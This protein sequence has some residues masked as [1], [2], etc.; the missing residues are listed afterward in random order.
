[1]LSQVQMEEIRAVQTVQR[2]RSRRLGSRELA[3]R[4]NVLSQL[5][6]LILENEKEWLGALYQDLKK[7]IVE[8]YSSELAVLLNEIEY[9]EKH[10]SRWMDPIKK[11]RWVFNGREKTET[12]QHPFGSILVIAPWNYPLQLALMPVIG[13][14]AAGNGIVLKPSEYAPSISQMLV[15]LVPQY[16][17]EEVFYV[18]EGGVETSKQ[19]TSLKWDFIF[20]T[21]SPTTGRKVYEAAAKNLT[22]VVLELGGKNPYIVDSSAMNKE[23]VQQIAWG[24]FLNA[25]QSC[26]APD[27]VYVQRESYDE[28]LTQMKATLIEFY[29]EKPEKAKDFGRIIHEKQFEKIQSYLADG[30]VF[31]GGVSSRDDLYISPTLLANPE[32][33]S[34][35]TIEEIFGPVLPIIPYDSLEDLLSTIAVQAVSLVTY[36]FSENKATIQHIEQSLEYGSLSVNQVI[37]HA[38][39]PHLSFGGKG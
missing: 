21:G 36:V 17:T 19:L 24:K 11:S 37:V 8:S 33:D 16:F 23:T 4:Q 2:E 14:L 38:A 26:I 15:E 30:S 35:V 29:G 3:E 27:T 10:L 6:L 5:K 13:A 20:F 32:S 7:P 25:G 1:M 9:V 18:V 12:S 39:S 34:P 28:F 31:Y 22:P